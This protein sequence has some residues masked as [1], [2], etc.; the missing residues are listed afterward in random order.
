M[1]AEWRKTVVIEAT[2]NPECHLYHTRELLTDEHVMSVCTPKDRRLE[3]FLAVPG[4]QGVTL[5][6]HLVQ[7]LKSPAYT[8]AEMDP[9]IL[10]VIG[11]VT[12]KEDKEAANG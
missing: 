10:A 5:Y 9:K 8:W 4:V 7:V 3:R 12:G 1:N 11:R 2:S 6:R